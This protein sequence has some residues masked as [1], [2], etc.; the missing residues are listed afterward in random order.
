M[1][2]LCFTHRAED[3]DHKYLDVSGAKDAR[4]ILTCTVPLGEIVTGF[5]DQLKS[6]SSGFASFE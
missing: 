3:V 1:M 4:I 6:R 2:D 5:F